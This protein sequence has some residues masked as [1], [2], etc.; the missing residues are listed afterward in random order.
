M[1][2][3]G[4]D[5]GAQT[6][7]HHTSA[8][9]VLHTLNSATIFLHSALS[10]TCR[11]TAAQDLLPDS[12][13]HLTKFHSLSYEAALWQLMLHLSGQDQTTWFLSNWE[14]LTLTLYLG[15]TN[16]K[17]CHS[18]WLSCWM[19]CAGSVTALQ[20]PS[21]SC[22]THSHFLDSYLKH[23]S[24]PF[25]QQATPTPL[26][27]IL[28]VLF[29][30]PL[31]LPARPLPENPFSPVPKATWRTLAQVW[32]VLTPLLPP[33]RQWLPT[34]RKL[35]WCREKQR[36]NHKALNRLS[37]HTSF[38]NREGYK[39]P[40][41]LSWQTANGK[42]VMHESC[43]QIPFSILK[44][45]VVFLT[46][47]KAE[48]QVLKICK[49]SKSGNICLWSTGIFLL[50]TLKIKYISINYIYKYIKEWEFFSNI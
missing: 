20:L 19:T 21:P 30:L 16:G 14:I 24:G 46:W 23:V 34:N 5:K 22:Y 7:Q 49:L 1:S 18:L 6:E 29:L 43:F 36:E 13:D 42:N 3:A 11:C 32:A 47:L 28:G 40:D 33:S 10:S 12:C 2:T 31:A 27:V 25:A 17:D 38:W 45:W 37:W 44:P 39:I 8:R 15:A 41:I 48:I 26:Q 35:W 9:Q 4:E 50:V